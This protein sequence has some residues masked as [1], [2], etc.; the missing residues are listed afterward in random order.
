MLGI[1]IIFLTMLFYLAPFCGAIQEQSVLQQINQKIATMQASLSAEQNKRESYIASLKAAEIA[2]GKATLKLQQTVLTLRKQQ[3]VLQKLNENEMFYRNQLLVNQNVLATQIR[4]AYA[5]GR[6][7][8][9]R[10]ALNQSDA[11]RISRL[12]KYYHYICQNRLMTIHHLQL[13]LNQ[14]QQTQQAIQD[15]TKLLTNLHAKQFDEHSKLERLKQDRQ[16]VVIQLNSKISNQQQ[17]LNELL[18][19]KR[20][21]EQTIT[22]LDKATQPHTLIKEDFAHSK[23]QLNWPTKG[24]IMPFFGTKIYQSELRWDGIL[25]Q[26]PENQPIYAV[27]NG[28]VVFAKWLPGYGLLLIISHGHGYMTLYGRNHTIY[29][30]S[31]DFVHAGDLIATVGDSGGYDQPALYFAIRHNAIPLNPMYW[32]SKKA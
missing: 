1:R 30:K 7:A 28:Q 16:F 9:L 3:T 23:G 8:Y 10:L 31:G 13:T 25:I 24:Q 26:A 17:K 18:T 32:C 29:K 27:A 5:L 14:L 2:P 22:H 11:N 21:L 12:L 4:S 20:L 6:Q 15:Q 19:N